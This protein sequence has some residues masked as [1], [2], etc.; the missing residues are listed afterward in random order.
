MRET[1]RDLNEMVRVVGTAR[2]GRDHRVVT[3]ALSMRPHAAGGDP[4]EGIRPVDGEGQFRQRLRDAVAATQMGQFVQYD[5]AATILR[6][7]RPRKSAGPPGANG[8]I[9]VICRVG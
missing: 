6:P 4:G 5:D 8:T 1:P 2:T 3:R 7:V 9:S